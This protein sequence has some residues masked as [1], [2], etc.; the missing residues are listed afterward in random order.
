MSL[1]TPKL[2]AVM[3]L[4]VKVQR[5]VEAGQVIHACGQGKRRIIP[6][7]GGTVRGQSRG[8]S[9][10]GLVLARGA[11]FQL[12]TS[13]STAQ[14]DARYILRLHDG[15]HIFVSNQ[16]VRTG[17]ANDIAALVCGESVPPERIYFR[18]A[19]RFEVENP[20]LAWMAQTLFAGTGARFPDR[21]ELAFYEVQ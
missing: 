6:I 8:Y 14:L 2:K 21:V 10:D 4:S 1:P 13:E 20:D 5:P 9:L 17:S 3:Q 12:V 18:C 19:P 16:A 11:D 15:S 7:T